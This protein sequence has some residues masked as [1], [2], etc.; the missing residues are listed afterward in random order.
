MD[1]A[2]RVS[3]EAQ[4]PPHGVIRSPADEVGMEVVLEQRER[5]LLGGGA[6]AYPWGGLEHEHRKAGPCQVGG[7]HHGVVPSSNKDSVDLVG[8]GHRSDVTHPTCPT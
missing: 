2:D 6:A 1:G 3:I 5:D 4:V 8:K 7:T